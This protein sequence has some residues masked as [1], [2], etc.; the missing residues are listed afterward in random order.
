MPDLS[1][2]N[3]KGIAPEAFLARFRRYPF[4]FL[5]YPLHPAK[6]TAL[7]GKYRALDHL[8]QEGLI[9]YHFLHLEFGI[10]ST[11][12]QFINVILRKRRI[13]KD[14]IVEFEGQAF[15]LFG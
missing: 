7:Q 15:I 11:V 13:I 10:A 6:G 8:K 3:K 1:P 5:Y 14:R 2:E 4:C 9:E 12:A